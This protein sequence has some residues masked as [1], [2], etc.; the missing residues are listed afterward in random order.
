MTDDLLLVA[1]RINAVVSRPHQRSLP[2]LDHCE[3]LRVADVDP[4]KEHRWQQAIFLQ[5]WYIS[6]GVYWCDKWNP[7]KRARAYLNIRRRQDSKPLFH[8]VPVHSCQNSILRRSIHRQQSAIKQEWGI[9]AGVENQ[10]EIPSLH[11]GYSHRNHA[12]FRKGQISVRLRSFYQ[13]DMFP[14]HLLL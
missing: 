7:V 6:S 4:P 12:S 5:L 9:A 10:M 8:S 11:T 13:R 1:A 3:G 14:L 2:W